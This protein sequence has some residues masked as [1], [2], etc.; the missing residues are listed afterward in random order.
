MQKKSI[1]K[2]EIYH[3]FVHFLRG[4]TYNLTHS[5][6]RDLQTFGFVLYFNQNQLLLVKKWLIHGAKKH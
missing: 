2:V 3:H 4:K 6:N 1:L 5:N